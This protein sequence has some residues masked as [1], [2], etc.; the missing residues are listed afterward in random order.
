[1]SQDT[2]AA[3]VGLR[4]GLQGAGSL[5]PQIDCRR[6]VIELDHLWRSSAPGDALLK[7]YCDKFDNIALGSTPC[8]PTPCSSSKSCWMRTSLLEL[9]KLIYI[10]LTGETMIN[11]KE[12]S[13]A[14]PGKAPL[15]EPRQVHADGHHVHHPQALRAIGRL[16]ELH[17]E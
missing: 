6:H 14:W 1:M 5:P 3:N 7:R 11:D 12:F 2:T 9:S 4:E 8:P 15:C 13:L 17:R 16:H 10:Y